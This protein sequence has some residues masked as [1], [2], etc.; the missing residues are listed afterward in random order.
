[1]KNRLIIA[2]C[3][4]TVLALS[5]GAAL[6]DN[7]QGYALPFYTIMGAVSSP[8]GTVAN[9]TVAFYMDDSSKKITAV[10]NPADNTYSLNAYDLYFKYGTEIM[11]ETQPYKLTVLPEETGWETTETVYLT[12]SQGYTEEGL[13]M[14]KSELL[15]TGQTTINVRAL[16][17]GFFPAPNNPTMN[18]NGYD[19]TRPTIVAELRTGSGP[20]NAT[21]I[22]ATSENTLLSTDGTGVLTFES[23]V[24]GSQKGEPGN[25]YIAVFQVL[26]NTNVLIP[27]GYNH[28]PIITSG[29]KYLA[30]GETAEIDLADPGSA[31]FMALYTPP[32]QVSAAREVNAQ[33]AVRVGHVADSKQM[34]IKD[35]NIIRDKAVAAGSSGVI[36]LNNAQSAMS[37]LNGDCILDIKDINL[38]RDTAKVFGAQ[39]GSH[40][41][42][43]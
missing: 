34:D 18:W 4:L 32:G 38:C 16:L 35:I 10:I 31:N 8:D 19:I 36:D 30:P 5:A 24:F 11:L 2:A 15:P 21:T 42:V 28:A 6:P 37:D 43:P 33:S 22:V 13:V 40:I 17:E 26:R 27:Y 12:N 20:E 14:A 7:P 41:Y 29:T 25:Y 3:L 39:S 1:M 23:D 9:T